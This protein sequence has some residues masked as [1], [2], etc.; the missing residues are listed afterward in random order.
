MS[1]SQLSLTCLLL[2]FLITCASVR[3]QTQ[4]PS[5][6]RAEATPQATLS[7]AEKRPSVQ[8]YTLPPEKYEQA[9]AFSR[10]RWALHFVGVAYSLALLLILLALKVAP[11]FRDWAEA[12]SRYRF[13]Q[14]LIF[15]PLLLLTLDVLNLPL[16]I[17]RQHLQLHYNQSVQ[18]WG[19]WLWDW[20]KAELIG[21]VIGTLLIWLLYAVLRRSP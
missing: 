13:V 14:A 9:I 20:T 11:K 17:Y 2:L 10:A 16:D 3:A 5:V 21:L 6:P 12:V 15:V 1:R 8:A 4:S 18:S 7:P 19:S